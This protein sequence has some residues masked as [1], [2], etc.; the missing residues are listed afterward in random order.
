MNLEKNMKKL[1]LFVII[2][3][4]LF[5]C[6]KTFFQPK[7]ND[8]L[9]TK[10]LALI[11]NY[12]E[13]YNSYDFDSITNILSYKNKQKAIER[14][15]N[16]RNL[17]GKYL[18]YK[19]P[20]EKFKLENYNECTKAKYKTEQ[21]FFSCL[22]KEYAKQ[23]GKQNFEDKICWKNRYAITPQD[24]GGFLVQICKT[25]KFENGELSGLHFV[26]EKDGKLELLPSLYRANE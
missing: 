6:Y 19:Y 21:E 1:F 20:N 14:I 23:Y 18:G 12:Y 9:L 16:A 10:S 8:E 24:N 3:A 7:N 17:S 15:K 22:G 13:Y 26:R 5:F 25:E 11:N 2:A 4:A